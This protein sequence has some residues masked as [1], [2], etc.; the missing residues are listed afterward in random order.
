MKNLIIVFSWI[1]ISISTFGFGQC[2]T[3]VSKRDSAVQAFWKTYW[4]PAS[5]K[6]ELE[7]W[8]KDSISRIL[9][10]AGISTKNYSGQVMNNG[11]ILSN[12]FAANEGKGGLSG[13]G[14]SPHLTTDYTQSSFVGDDGSSSRLPIYVDVQGGNAAFGEPGPLD[15]IVVKKGKSLAY[16]FPISWKELAYQLNIPILNYLGKEV[17][18]GEYTLTTGHYRSFLFPGDVIYWRLKQVTDKDGHEVDFQKRLRATER[19]KQSKH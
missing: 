17:S 10:R 6:A 11:Q 1:F 13:P 7:T 9:C 8:Q 4:L 19:A 5:K 18:P 3:V 16:Y 14:N 12:K 2:D 15:K